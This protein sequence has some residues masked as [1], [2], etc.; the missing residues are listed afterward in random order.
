[1]SQNYSH[2]TEPNVYD[3]NL[4][5]ESFPTLSE[6]PSFSKKVNPSITDPA[7]FSF[8]NPFHPMRFSQFLEKN[9][10]TK[11]YVHQD[12]Q[13]ENAEVAKDD[14]SATT[15]QLPRVTDTQMMQHIHLLHRPTCNHENNKHN[16]MMVITDNKIFLQKKHVDNH[17]EDNS[18]LTNDD[19]AEVAD[20]GL[21]L[22]DSHI[23]HHIELIRR[24]VDN[25]EHTLD[26][27]EDELLVFSDEDENHELI[28]N[29]HINQ[30]SNRLPYDP[31]TN[32]KLMNP[33][34]KMMLCPNLPALLFEE[35][36]F[37]CYGTSNKKKRVQFNKKIEM[38][39]LETHF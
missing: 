5:Y 20:H 35:S 19:R 24:P 31:I 14:P 1:M 13:Y 27:N 36:S 28:C 15:K 4:M 32:H 9:K 39:Y 34:F 16:N 7:L 22:T 33:F 23:M 10:Q 21:R 37:G 2:E 3:T 11:P 18:V 26:D 17:H 8:Y 38:K 12:Q 25:I 29:T 30:F 6:S